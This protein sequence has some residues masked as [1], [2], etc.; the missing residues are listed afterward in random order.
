M[1]FNL[2]EGVA[3]LERTPGVL[4]GLLIG[5]PEAWIRNNEGPDTWSPFDVVGH[6]ITGEETDWMARLHIILGQGENR[7]FARFDRFRQLERD[8]GRPLVD[9]LAEFRRLRERNLEELRS[10]RLTREQ[11][12][13][14][15]EHPTFG[16]VTAEHLLSTWVAHDLGHLG[17]IA[18]VMAKQY[19]DAVGPWQEFLPI[20]HR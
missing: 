3:V 6:L 9:L 15:G 7:R 18:R 8:Q 13:L 20:L 5:L 16:T 11:F 10:L 17:Q 12:L 4:E 14:T 1:N 19:R 2:D